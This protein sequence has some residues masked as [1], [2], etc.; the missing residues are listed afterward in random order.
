MALHKKLA[1]TR[2]G[3]SKLDEAEKNEVAIEEFRVMDE[4]YRLRKKLHYM[5]RV[6]MTQIYLPYKADIN[7]VLKD[8]D[9]LRSTIE[10]LSQRQF[11]MQTLLDSVKWDNFKEMSFKERIEFYKEVK[12]MINK[13]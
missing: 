12:S 1:F 6:F 13:I 5:D 4:I 9:N 7:G 2:K 11:E 10:N 8:Y 3:W